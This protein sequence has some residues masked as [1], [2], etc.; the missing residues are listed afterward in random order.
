MRNGLAGYKLYQTAATLAACVPE[1]QGGQG[2]NAAH[3]IAACIRSGRLSRLFCRAADVQQIGAVQSS[4][5]SR[6]A[7]KTL[8]KAKKI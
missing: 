2:R 8:E 3:I 4:N 5:D 1:A 6:S 7:D